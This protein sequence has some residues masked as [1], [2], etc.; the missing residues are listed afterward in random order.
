MLSPPSCGGPFLTVFFH[1]YDLDL[2]ND[3][4]DGLLPSYNP[5]SLPPAP[6]TD[7]FRLSMQPSFTAP[8]FP[9]YEPEQAQGHKDSGEYKQSTFRYDWQDNLRYLDEFS[10]QYHDELPNFT[11]VTPQPRLRPQASSFAPALARRSFEQRLLP[12]ASSRSLPIIDAVEPDT[13]FEGRRPY[14]HDGWIDSGYPVISSSSSSRSSAAAAAHGAAFYGDPGMGEVDQHSVLRKSTRTL[15]ATGGVF[16]RYQEVATPY[17]EATI[18]RPGSS[19]GRFKSL[20][21]SRDS[22]VFK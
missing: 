17:V 6:G 19:G 7:P 18:S 4:L 2:Q 11:Q 15:P 14:E 8:T 12:Q 16:P 10:S 13:A 20:F 21:K 22:R 9:V 3:S 5:Y 1:S